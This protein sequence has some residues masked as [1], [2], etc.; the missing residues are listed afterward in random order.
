MK[1]IKILN[2]LLI[3]L[4]SYGILIS[5]FNIYNLIAFRWPT[6]MFES[7]IIGEYHPFLGLVFSILFW[8]GIVLIQQGI[9]NVIKKGLFNK[10]K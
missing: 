2:G 1:K 8:I 6:N 4:I 7:S 5:I 3:I 9:S 10:K